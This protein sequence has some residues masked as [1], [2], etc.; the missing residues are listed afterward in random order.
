M[1]TRKEG[2]GLQLSPGEQ[3]LLRE[4][5]QLIAREVEEGEISQEARGLRRQNREAVGLQVQQPQLGGVPERGPGE[6][7]Q[8]IPGQPQLTQA[9]Q[10][11]QHEDTELREGVVGQPQ[12]LQAAQCP[13]GLS[14][15]SAYG[16]PLHAQSAGVGRNRR[17][18]QGHVRITAHHGPGRKSGGYLSKDPVS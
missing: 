5:H 12:L 8:A 10:S 3:Q 18:G 14:G 13:E 9:S 4:P 11:P 7:G 17:W 15:Y 16:R 1:V 6:G 2:P